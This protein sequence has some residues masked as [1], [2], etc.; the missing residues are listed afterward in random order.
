MENVQ[1][2]FI[3]FFFFNASYVHV[4]RM[5][6][7][8]GINAVAFKRLRSLSFLQGFFSLLIKLHLSDVKQGILSPLSPP[9]PLNVHLFLWQTWH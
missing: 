8:V 2:F 7:E 5:W 3:L 6:D 9:V 4:L 1:A